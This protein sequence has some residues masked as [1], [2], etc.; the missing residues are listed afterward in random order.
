VT[1]KSTQGYQ[2]KFIWSDNSVFEESEVYILPHDSINE[3]S[4]VY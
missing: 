2:N 4:I 3:N 1:R